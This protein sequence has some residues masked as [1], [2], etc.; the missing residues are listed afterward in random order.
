MGFP[1][2]LFL[3]TPCQTCGHRHPTPPRGRPTRTH[4]SPSLAGHRAAARP[5]VRD[6]ASPRALGTQKALPSARLSLLLFWF[7]WRT[8]QTPLPWIGTC[9]N[10]PPPT[11]CRPPAGQRGPGLVEERQRVLSNRASAGRTAGMLGGRRAAPGGA[12]F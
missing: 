6:A 9:E 2:L 11:R 1:A 7:H 10:I 8:P 4:R 5:A 12:D 3:R